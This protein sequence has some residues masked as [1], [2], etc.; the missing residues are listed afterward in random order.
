MSLANKTIFIS[1]A[2]RGI[3]EAIALR[4]A[5]DGANVVITG[6]SDKPHPK[7]PGTIHSVAHAC[8]QA[9]GKA[10]AI[11]MDVREEDSIVAAMDK[12]AEH[13]GGIDVLVNNASAISLTPTLETKAKRYDLMHSVNARGTFLCSKAAIKYL[14]KADNPHILTLSPPLN[15]QAKWFKDH[16]AYSMSKFGMSMCTLGLS[17]ELKDDAIAANS[18]WPK[19]TIAT[20]AIE[21]NFPKELMAA[22]RKPSIMAD[23]AYYIFNQPSST[24]TGQFLVDEAVLVESGVT[25]FDAYAVSPGVPLYPDFFLEH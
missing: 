8:E 5:F 4:C 14:K 23:A 19:T 11:A 6:K 2:S 20:A 9:G 24:Y 21:Y 18:L 7:L 15:M 12:A 1:G 13:F 3:G 16:L 22:S 17:A 10:L 25:D